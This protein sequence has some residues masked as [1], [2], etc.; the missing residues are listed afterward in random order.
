MNKKN[1]LKIENQTGKNKRHGCEKTWMWKEEE[2]NWRHIL[3]KSYPWK[4]KRR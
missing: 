2:V 4:K 1:K 3:I